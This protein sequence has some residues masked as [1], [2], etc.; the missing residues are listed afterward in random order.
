VLFF[1]NVEVF[2]ESAEAFVTN[3][4]VQGA[5]LFGLALVNP[6]PGDEFAVAITLFPRVVSFASKSGK[7]GKV[8]GRLASKSDGLT[9]GADETFEILDGVRRSKSAD[10]VG[11]KTIPGEIFESGGKSLGVT[12]LRID[13]L[14]SPKTTIDISDVGGSD[15]FFKNN[16][17]PWHH[18]RSRS[19]VVPKERQSVRWCW[20]RLGTNNG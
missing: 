5:V 10:F 6:I 16:L 19:C 8:L 2:L 18:H 20:I 9:G 12:D 17:A 3:E 7:V 1:D 13:S 4:N 15:R 11:N 14:R